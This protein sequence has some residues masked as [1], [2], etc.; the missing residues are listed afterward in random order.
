ME[1]ELFIKEVRS[2]IYLLDEG[3]EATGYLVVGEEKACVID[4][5][6]GWNDLCAAVRRL[7]DKP[8]V[9]VNTH[10]HPDH[11]LGN[12]YFDKEIDHALISPRDRALAESFF[13]TIPEVKE[14]C[15]KSGHNV[16]PFGD[17]RE[18]DVI[19]LG[20]RTL[21]VFELAGH[22]DGELL[23]LLREDRILFT[24]DG[25]NHHLWLQLDGCLPM[26]EV[27]AELDRLM[28]LEEMADVILHGHARDF[29]DISLMG[30]LRNGIAE[31]CEGRNENDEPYNWFGG[32]DL[33]HH[34]RCPE[35]KHYQQDDHV[36]CYRKENLPK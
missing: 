34:F 4:T 29:D 10:G 17:I 15:R 32:T 14:M 5:M 3:H 25:I 2:G 36:I 22:T 27:L 11:I 9:L 19:D 8:L 23:L 12:I 35:D 16:P 20:G 30:C 26:N 13:E 6:N 21:E 31:L 18:G 24:G 33:Q 1:H 28:F 7:T